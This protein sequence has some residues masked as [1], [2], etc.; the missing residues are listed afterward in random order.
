MWDPMLDM[1]F[2]PWLQSFKARP[3]IACDIMR[4]GFKTFMTFAVVLK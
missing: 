2:V 1:G 3:T 4:D